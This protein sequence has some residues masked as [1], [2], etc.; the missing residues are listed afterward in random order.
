MRYT[1]DM[2]KPRPWGYYRILDK[3]K[4]YQVKH[5]FVMAGKR[6]SYQSHEYRNEHWFIVNGSAKVTVEGKERILKPGSYLSISAK[7][8]HRIEALDEDV[9]FIEIQTGSYFGEDDIERFDDD[10]GRV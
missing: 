8:K 5:I 4:D 10:Y 2:I 3:G 6:L 1:K 7:T 9:L